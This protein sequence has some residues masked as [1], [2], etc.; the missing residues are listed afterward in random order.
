MLHNKQNSPSYLAVM[1]KNVLAIVH[2]EGQPALFLTFSPSESTWIDLLK[3]LYE[4]CY[5]ETLFDDKAAKF[6]YT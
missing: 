6:S 5:S 1:R 2:Q 3:I 4:F